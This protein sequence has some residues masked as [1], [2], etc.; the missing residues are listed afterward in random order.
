MLLRLV[1]LCYLVYFMLLTFH[2]HILFM[3][4]VTWDSFL[5]YIKPMCCF[6]MYF[7]ISIFDMIIIVFIFDFIIIF[8][9][10]IS[11]FNIF[12][13]LT[14]TS[15]LSLAYNLILF[16]YLSFLLYDSIDKLIFLSDLFALPSYTII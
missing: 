11:M 8:V 7:F 9:F 5:T 6:F 16:L 12:L 10:I 15:F 4:T 14:N 3:N 13:A 2:H 1:R